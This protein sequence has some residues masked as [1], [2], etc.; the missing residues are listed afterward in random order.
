MMPVDH[1]T[2]A[3]LAEV[4]V[5][6]GPGKPIRGS[7]Y[8]VA[9]GWVLTCWHVVAEATGIAVWLGSPPVLDPADGEGV[10]VSAVLAFPRADIALLPVNR[11]AEQDEPV[12]W[13]RLDRDVST[14]VPVV[15]AGFPRFKLRPSPHRPGVSLRDVHFAAGHVQAAS[16]R[17]TETLELS[18]TA[19]TTP[20][21]DPEPARHSPWEGM[22]GAAVWGA[23]RIVGVVAQHHPGDGRGT[24]TVLTIEDLLGDAVDA[25][26]WAGALY[27]A[28]GSPGVLSLATSPTERQLTVRRAQSAAARVA[29]DVLVARD[30]Q[31]ERLADFAASADR[32]RWI[33]GEAFA[34]KSALLA[35]FALHPPD[36]TDVAACFLRRIRAGENT[37]EYAVDVL[38]RQLAVLGDRPGYQS[39]T[40]ASE[41]L[42][43]FL[44]LLSEAADA[45]RARGR[46][47]LLLV[48]GL[49][50]YQASGP[51]LGLDCWI[52]DESALPDGAQL[53]VSSRQG[54]HLPLPK[55]HPLW[56]SID[57]IPPSEAAKDLQEQATRELEAAVGD[58]AGDLALPTLT[59]LVAAETGLTAPEL[60]AL[61]RKRGRDP[62]VSE[63]CRPLDTAFHRTLALQA[64]LDHP[65][66][67]VYT[68]AHVSL[69]SA[70]SALVRADLPAY[71]SLLDSWADEYADL[72]WPPETPRYLHLPYTAQL[73][74]RAQATESQAECRDLVDRAYR[75]VSHRHRQGRVL[76]RSG[77]PGL[78][79]Q[80]ITDTQQILLGTRERSEL[81]PDE[82][83][84]RLAVLA[85][86][87][88]PLT[89][90]AAQIVADVVGVW[91]RCGRADAAVTLA[92]HIHDGRQRDDALVR[93]ARTLAALR[94]T[95]RALGVTDVIEDVHA[96]DDALLDV[97]GAFRV[98]GDVDRA[99]ETTARLSDRDHRSSALAQIAEALAAS[100]DA[101]AARDVA[102]RIEDPRQ[103]DLA[104]LPVVRVLAGRGDLGDAVATAADIADTGLQV[105]ALVAFAEQAVT[106]GSTAQ[107]VEC[108]VARAEPPGL[109]ATAL[110]EIARA[111][112][113]SGAVVAGIGAAEQAV[114]AASGIEAAGDKARALLAISNVLTRARG[115]GSALAA[116]EQTLA[117]A[118]HVDDPNERARA[119]IGVAR[120]FAE[121]GHAQH[122]VEVVQLVDA[123]YMRARAFAEVALALAVTGSADAALETPERIDDPSVRAS[124]FT[125][126]ARAFARVGLQ[127]ETAAAAD[128]AA[129]AVSDIEHPD[130]R[131]RA[132][133]DLAELLAAHVSLERAL[134]SADGIDSPSLRA[135]GVLVVARSL[136]AQ[137]RF[138]PAIVATERAQTVIEDIDRPLLRARASSDLAGVYAACGRSDQA[139]SAVAGITDPQLRA[140][141]LADVALSLVAAHRY[142]DAVTTASGIDDPVDQA[143][144]LGDV[145]QA[146]AM[147]GATEKA[148]AAATQIENVGVRVRAL[149]DVVL[150]FAASGDSDGVRAAAAL[151]PDLGT[152]VRVLSEA[153]RTLVA[154]DR[155]DEAVAVAQT[156]R[157]VVAG[158]D[159]PQEHAGDIASVAQA[160]L[161][162]G[163][164][165][166]ARLL[167]DMIDDPDDRAGVLTEVALA[168]SSTDDPAA[169]LDAAG[170]I[171]EAQ[172]RAGAL[173]AVAGTFAEAGHT[174]LA[175]HAAD[176]ALDAG[177]RIADLGHQQR[178]L[179]ALTKAP[180]LAWADTDPTR[181]TLRRIAHSIGLAKALTAVEQASVA[182]PDTALDTAREI[183][184]VADRAV[185]FAVIAQA[186]VAA[187]KPSDALL[188]A[189]AA[190]AAVT[191]LD[192]PVARAHVLSTAADACARAVPADRTAD[193]AA[194]VHDPAERAAAVTAVADALAGGYDDEA[195]ACVRR[196]EEALGGLHGDVDVTGLLSGIALAYAR[197]R[198][199]VSAVAAAN[200]IGDMSART[201]TLAGVARALGTAGA[202]VA[203]LDLAADLVRVAGDIEHPYHQARVLAE[204]ASVFVGLDSRAQALAAAEQAVASANRVDDPYL[205][206]Q[207]LTHAGDALARGGNAGRAVHIASHIDAPVLR[208]FA[209][210]TVAQSLAAT[211]EVDGALAAIAHIDDPDDASQALINLARTL[212]ALGRREQAL[213]AAGRVTETAQRIEHLDDLARALAAVAQVFVMADAPGQAQS[214]AN[215]ALEAAQRIEEQALRV[216]A[217]TDVARALAASGSSERAVEIAETFDDRGDRTTALTAIAQTLAHDH[218]PEPPYGDASPEQRVLRQLIEQVL[219]TPD[220]VGALP[221][222]PDMTLRRLVIEGELC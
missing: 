115:S 148:V 206:A 211:G 101:D 212:V 9:P 91:A 24:L 191:N 40:Y 58:A 79:D 161:V 215:Q 136:A 11:S 74:A 12:R 100:G 28:P 102:R 132:L 51:G 137:G 43:D 131:A 50:E 193:T 104:L 25:A 163:D 30:A 56:N 69:L 146:L 75:V 167:A 127:P 119:Y 44:D 138:E 186:L 205:R 99:I 19:D 108:A 130:H 36:E 159:S 141:T 114:V 22:S 81:D 184:D 110:T 203:A 93:V 1:P 169:A 216:P 26:R 147:A 156:A 57:V 94:Q 113:T 41:R 149:S 5:A 35:W 208:S 200:R 49:D 172:L 88:K 150:A 85:F 21:E 207:A 67:V 55:N 77:N 123:P 170:Q 10:D 198:D 145:A 178:L 64:D 153:A 175:L 3:R 194:A 84:Y 168:L 82:I 125:D 180:A 171:D 210:A 140:R 218:R 20:G 13:G 109:A 112:A 220:V 47:L 90:H 201:T 76:A 78:A 176:A 134:E 173:I 54:T 73:T 185:A 158:F 62:D 105:R 160:L 135:Y 96:R 166:A 4:V 164:A 214:A 157:S 116:T 89:G 152:R 80:E 221:A 182:G 187:G 65:D 217:L 98:M 202:S 174:D 34:G 48:D 59:C 118:H 83:L 117:A 209:L 120:A 53:L 181:Q 192:D 68:F 151:I 197:A 32:W 45:C 103:R 195:I 154:A 31:L 177:D 39:A 183:D 92:E 95:S 162:V 133:V 111:L 63:V 7:G 124:S 139:V 126:C 199:A 222:L 66:D 86:R 155:A 38:S 23:N 142:E 27:S 6:R 213:V 2:R 196:A 72:G 204:I 52:P 129:R 87:R 16:N 18:V 42:D 165:S 70:A 29:P 122:A 71:R 37:F 106:D 15:T 8:L 97:I 60:T 179:S 33:T 144:A 190:I 17:K 61:L 188:A 128:G 14:P 107:A 219:L 189:D 143:R 121:A 46:R